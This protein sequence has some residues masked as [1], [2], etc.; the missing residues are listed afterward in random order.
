[1]FLIDPSEAVDSESIIPS[2]HRHFKIIEEKK[3]GWDIT[4]LLFKDIAHNF[5]DDDKETK[6]LL[7]HIFEMED[8]YMKMTGRSDATFGIYQKDKT[9]TDQS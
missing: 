2:I 5:L 3:L 6:G 8:E 9:S 4:W 1:M 7:R